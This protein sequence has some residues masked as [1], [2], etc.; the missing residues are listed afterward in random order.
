MNPTLIVTKEDRFTDACVAA[1]LAQGFRDPILDGARKGS[2]S[3][4]GL[5]LWALQAMLVVRQFTRFI[6][7]IHANCPDR[8]GQRLLAENL[9]E[10][11]G[12]G[13]AGNDHYVLI[14]RLARSLG[15]TDS[16]IAGA[17]PLPE[18]QRYIDHCFEVTRNAPFVES[19]GAIA[20][21]IEYF[22]PAFFGA[23][24][25]AMRLNY[26]LSPE[27]VE[28]LAVHVNEDAVHARRSAELIDKFAGSE[29]ARERVLQ[30]LAEMLAVKRRFAEA[31]YSHCKSA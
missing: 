18:T 29:G 11:H 28:Y 3:R 31:L 26:G 14:Q 1:V 8:E 17:E 25:E 6:S 12:R 15:A 21:G 20:L 30:A 2:I 19:L 13:D 7:A 4:Q 27:D 10:E 5:K 16:E 22:M 24:S 9:W 23:L